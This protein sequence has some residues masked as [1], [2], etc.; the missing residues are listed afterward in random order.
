VPSQPAPAVIEATVDELIAHA[1]FDK[2]QADSV[3]RVAEQIRLHYFAEG[4]TILSPAAGVVDTLWLVQRG[5]VKGAAA[6]SSASAENGL[7]LA[8]GEM[9]PLGAMLSKRATVLTFTAA[10][11][12]FCYALDESLF[13]TLMDQSREFR[14]F[15]TTRLAH[16]LDQSRRA[17]QNEFSQRNSSEQT[18]SSP[19]A[20]IIRRP[21][22]TVAPEVAISEV[23]KMM[24]EQR[25]GSVV[26]TDPAE[27][28]PLGIFTERDV[29]S[30]VAIS[31]ISQARPIAEVMTPDPFCLSAEAPVFDAAKAMAER[32]FRHVLVTKDQRLVGV[33][34]E[35]DLFQLQRL[36]LGEIAKSI[37]R[38]ADAETLSGAAADVRRMASALVAQGVAAEQLTQFVTTMNDAIVARALT[39][40]ATK[41]AP[42]EVPWCWI[43]LG[44]EGRM[45]QTL[46]TDQDNAIIF[47]SRAGV[48]LEETRTAF[49]AF[50]AEVNSILN[51]AGFPFCLG[52]IMARN[53]QW[54]LEVNEWRETFGN[55]MT[56]ANSQA[57]LNAAI[58]F[59]LRGLHGELS[60][61]HA[62]RQW[63]AETIKDQP[64]FLRLMAGNALQVR[65]PLGVV[66]DFVDVDSEFPGTIDLK[67]M[68][69]RPFIDAA[70]V[71]ALAHDVRATNTAERLR[72][73]MHVLRSS[74]EEIDAYVEAFHYIQLQRLRAADAA[75]GSA[76]D[77]SA[78]Q[79]NRI[80]ID[81][82]NDLDR[83]I[84][85][86]A[87]R[88]A[89][90]LQ[91]R[92]EMDFQ[93]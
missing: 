26:I 89:R 33:V 37:D 16:L 48:P 57:L 19:L 63:L 79:P 1:P 85:K 67:K 68:A 28:K 44:S 66:R 40:A 22:I 84:L 15:A 82:L 92:L 20:S 90:K 9:F 34:S 24:H 23:L 46:A 72:Q 2:M 29:L 14:Q 32:R 31:G 21:P 3:R 47:E 93:L 53:P 6:S 49:V 91:S 4:A 88:Q 30:R 27:A 39:L 13:Q 25:I 71:L 18:L 75:K 56:A 59:D 45:E 58:F 80:T 43:G 35:R 51:Q 87:L 54:C 52:N 74:R 65:P 73:S 77:K 83:R 12:V 10:T 81:G 50:A 5:S 70:R 62:L 41:S 86:E 7:T 36:S 64:L 42:P 78:G 17:L 8:A 11:D 61:A 76:D 38:A 60:L 69:A 55:W